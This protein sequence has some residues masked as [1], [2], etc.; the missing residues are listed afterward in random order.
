MGGN[1][2]LPHKDWGLSCCINYYFDPGNAITCWY[3][4]KLTAS[5]IINDEYK[6]YRY[7]PQ[8]IVLVDKFI[9]EKNDCYLLN[10]SKI[11]SVMKSKNHNRQFIQIQYDTPYEIIKE[12]LKYI[13]FTTS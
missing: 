11:H 8:D 7:D 1:M 4:E 6:I 13:D 9:A 5:P 2:I 3:N 10:N 12:K